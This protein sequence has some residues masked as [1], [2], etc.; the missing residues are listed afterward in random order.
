MV[1]AA[2]VLLAAGGGSRFAGQTH[3]L[4]APVSSAP[5]GPASAGAPDGPA[6][7]GTADRASVAHTVGG[8][9]LANMLAANFAANAVVW[10]AVAVDDLLAEAASSQPGTATHP[11]TATSPQVVQLHNPDWADGIATSLAVAVRWAHEQRHDVLVVGLADQP[12]I[13]PDAWRA[14][15]QAV[16]DHQAPSVAVA[17]YDGQPANP[18]ALRRDV[19]HLLP[20]TGDEGARSLVRSEKVA[21]APVACEGHPHDVDTLEDLRRWN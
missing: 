10:G 17:T 21:W 3:K 6:S 18:V 2:A 5:N 8:R 13:S 20:T 12:G 9:S 14:V 15:A 7:P 19:W 1:N 4:F 11:G 16:A